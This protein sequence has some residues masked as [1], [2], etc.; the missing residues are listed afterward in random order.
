MDYEFLNLDLTGQDKSCFNNFEASRRPEVLYPPLETPPLPEKLFQEIP[1]PQPQNMVSTANLSC[2]LDLERLAST[3]GNVVYK[4]SKFKG[5]I[6]RIRSPN[7]TALI[8]TTGKMVCLGTKSESESYLAIRKFARIVQKLGFAVKL[9]DFYVQ[10]IVAS[11]DLNF[12]LELEKL[13]MN[14]S[15]LFNFDPELFPGLVCKMKKPKVVL[16]I[17]RSGK[18]II[19]GAKIINSVHEAFQNIYPLLKT[20]ARS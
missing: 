13:S 15:Y 20:H 6:M 1:I 9:K 3:A 2:K 5:L 16:L 8:F 12:T 11:C 14:K 7:A 18:I 19:T 17:F 10:N 4:P